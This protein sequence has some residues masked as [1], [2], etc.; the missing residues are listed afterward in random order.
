M[1]SLSPVQAN[2]FTFKRQHLLK[3]S[4]APLDVTR[5]LIVIQTQY[6][7][8]L[9]GALWARTTSLTPEWVDKALYEWRKLVKTWTVRTTLHTLNRDDL[10]LMV[11]AMGSSLL[12][13]FY[14]FMQRRRGIKRQELR[15]ISTKVMKL[16]ADG[17][18]SRAEIHAKIPL[19]ADMEGTGWG[20]DVF[21]LA[22]QGDVLFGEGKTFV[23]RDNWLPDLMWE[24]QDE[25]I[26]RQDLLR[27]YLAAYGPA[28]IQDFAFWAGMRVRDAREIWDTIGDAVVPVDVD[29]WKGDYY[30]RA[31]DVS[32][33]GDDSLPECA[34]LPKFDVINV[35]YKD[36][37]RFLD[38]A[39]YKR[40][41]RA[42][43]QIEAVVL[44]D[45]RIAGT[46]RMKQSKDVL[47]LTIEPHRNFSPR[48]MQLLNDAAE[49][50]AAFYDADELELM[51]AEAVL[52]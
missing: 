48:E 26:A 1:L 3:P 17:A 45:G 36:K 19:L 33:L 28:T 29:G 24:L 18:L 31:E 27:R 46:W 34:L 39:D 4:P 25:A 11:A 13:N 35:S 42:A 7:A 50:L 38:E 9:P 32:L 52:S 15:K 44:F 30:L 5:D 37:T 6:A 47:S 40:V 21:A 10:P 23:R 22:F 20:L 41:Y 51:M 14:H 12:D 8:S 43:G 49:R 16:L 2:S